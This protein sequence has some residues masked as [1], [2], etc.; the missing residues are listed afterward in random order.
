MA[1]PAQRCLHAFRAICSMEISGPLTP[2]AH[3]PFL[4]EIVDNLS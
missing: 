1:V 2:A 3:M 4:T